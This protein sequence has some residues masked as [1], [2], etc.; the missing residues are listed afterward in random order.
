MLCDKLKING[1][2]TEFVVIGTRQ[3][4]SKVHVDSLAVGDAQVSPVQMDSNMSLQV[5]ISNTCKAAYYYITNVRRI[6]KYLSNQATQTLVHALIIGR[7]D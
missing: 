7:I 3:Q 4:L 6:R 5:N 1:G 2:K